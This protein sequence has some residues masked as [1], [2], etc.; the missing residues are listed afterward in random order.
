MLSAVSLV[1]WN[2]MKI[3]KRKTQILFFNFQINMSF[4]NFQ[5]WNEIKIQKK[6][7]FHFNFNLKIEWHFQ[8]TDESRKWFQNKTNFEKFSFFI[9]KF[10]NK[11]WKMKDLFEIHFLFK[12]KK[13]IQK[14]VFCFLKLVLNQNGVKNIFFRF[15]FFNALIKFEKSK[16][17]LRSVFSFQIKK[18]ITKLKCSFYKIRL[19]S[20]HEKLKVAKIKADNFE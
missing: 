12:I 14:F 3:G 8:C 1:F 18:R 4:F 19:N 13:W 20:K 10:H 11:N 2:K 5:S 9:V 6:V 16:Y 15:S 7:L 17:F